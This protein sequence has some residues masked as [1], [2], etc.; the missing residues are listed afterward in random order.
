MQHIMVFI[1]METE[2]N[3]V[4]HVHVYGELGLMKEQVKNLR[5]ILLRHIE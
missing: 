5:N 4:T 3:S 1:E 2:T